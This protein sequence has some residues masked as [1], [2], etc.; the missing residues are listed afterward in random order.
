VKQAAPDIE[1]LPAVDEHLR[2]REHD[3]HRRDAA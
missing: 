2:V 1:E 3:G